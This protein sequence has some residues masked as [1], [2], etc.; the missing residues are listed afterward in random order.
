MAVIPYRKTELAD[1]DTEWDGEAERKAAEI[2][3]LKVMCAWYA[4]PGDMKDDY[5]LPHHRARDHACVL[6]GVQSAL[7][8]LNATDMPEADRPA[9]RAHLEEH[10][11]EFALTPGP[12]SRGRGEMALTPGPSSRGRGEMALTPAPSPAGRGE[13]V[14]LQGEVS[15]RAAGYRR[16]E[17]TAITAGNGNGLTYSEAVLRAACPLF[18][19][20]SVFVD[21]A[22]L[23]EMWSQT[24][25]RSLRNVLGVL[26]HV[27]FSEVHRGICGE[28]RIYPGV[29]AAWFCAMVD[30]YLADKASGLAVPRIGLS[31]VVD[32]RT[33]G[34]EVVSI[35][36][37]IS[38]DAVFDPA[39]GGE[40]IRAI[41]QRV[42]ARTTN[43]KEE[44][45][46]MEEGTGYPVVDNNRI[47]EALTP[48][49][50]P[51]GRGESAL[52]PNP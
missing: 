4:E 29:D 9:V 12:S 15:G 23:P 21:H 41:N 47:G 18:E 14:V 19:G 48:N 50:S 51:R 43:K 7:H 42:E 40:F 36:R 37:V 8:L 35:E 34:R 11:R 1:P 10:L 27:Y 49:P 3:D 2:E 45:E 32:V 20:V 39:R 16:Y 26:E 38:V 33:K 13:M 31:A 5:K 44:N 52:T 25:G 6:A 24:G 17:V 30:Q 46:G 28:L 22:Q